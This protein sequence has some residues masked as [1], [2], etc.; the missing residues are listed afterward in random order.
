MFLLKKWISS[1]AQTFN[2]VA[3]ASVTAMMLLTCADV[4]LRIFR[5]PIP[6]TYEIIG[7]LG[8]VLV[9]FSLAYTSMQ[10]GHIAVDFL[11]QKLPKKTQALIE[12]I[13][14]LTCAIFFG[15]I[16]WQSMAYAK[17]LQEVGEVS[18]TL[19]IP[20]HPFV[21]GIALGCG[22][23]SM[24]LIMRFIGSVKG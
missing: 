16:A 21:Y 10:R 11:V 9:S 3:V 19:Q 20:I 23:L 15:L 13:N 8:A 24:V 22:M 4:I 7:L 5:R 14:S 6:G 2:W 18:M 1:L 17:D 12:C